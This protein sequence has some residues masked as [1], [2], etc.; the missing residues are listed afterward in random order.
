MINENLLEILKKVKNRELSIEDGTQELH[1]IKNNH[2]EVLFYQ[3]DSI[4]TNQI[5]HKDI[6]NE[7]II[8]LTD[9]VELSNVIKSINLDHIGSGNQLLWISRAKSFKQNFNS[10][11]MDLNNEAHFEQLSNYVYSAYDNK[12]IR[13]IYMIGEHKPPIE[14]DWEYQVNSTAIIALLF[15]KS[16]AYRFQKNGVR[17]Q[18]FSTESD[19]KIAVFQESVVVLGRSIEKEVPSF[20]TQVIIV[21]PGE[22][23][24]LHDVISTELHSVIDTRFTYYKSDKRMTYNISEMALE[25]TKNYQEFPEGVYVILGGLGAI[26]KAVTAEIA[27]LSDTKI[28]LVGRR[29]ISD[30]IETYIESLRN[31]T[32]DITYISADISNDTDIKRMFH[33][34]RSQF[35]KIDYVFHCAGIL[36]DC[37]LPNKSVESFKRVISSK[38]NGALAIIDMN[39]TYNFKKVLFFSS[40]SGVF[41]NEGQLDYAYANML[42]NSLCSKDSDSNIVSISWPFWDTE[43]MK[44]PK[45]YKEKIFSAYGF[46]PMPTREG[47]DIIKHTLANNSKSSIVLYGDRQKLEN[48]SR[49]ANTN[50]YIE[51]KDSSVN[52]VPKEK[53]SANDNNDG[54]LDSVIM[55]ITEIIS[56]V[57]GIDTDSL[58]PKKSIQNL[59]IDSVMTT[60]INIEFEKVF[61]N[62]SKTLLFEYR[63]IKEIAEHFIQN[64]YDACKNKFINEKTTEDVVETVHNEEIQVTA[65]DDIHGGDSEVFEIAIIGIA[66]KYPK[67]ESLD[68]F[69][70]NL[71]AGMDCIDVIPKSRWD[72]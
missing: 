36:E 8:V 35:E 21:K 61:D 24:S 70:E 25:D 50:Q 51:S 69:W 41:G 28:I 18:I 26:G 7:Y 46:R 53:M 9:D 22:V 59:G 65:N 27:K 20:I 5:V 1:N 66:G 57:T 45:E 39:R 23:S 38:I 55:W 29:K 33:E 31:G 56:K 67:A 58:T 19:A 42:I 64:Y 16:F 34:V 49:N 4:L 10:I 54:L 68:A 37:K 11:E 60:E 2:S 44:M 32:N 71:K 48:F 14:N 62:I 63:C 43:G 12:K 30:E 52:T 15:A 40:T 13:I 17:F 72:L 47:I 6:A 3:S